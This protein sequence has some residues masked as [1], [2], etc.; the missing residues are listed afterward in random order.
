M[1]GTSNAYPDRS[2]KH[3]PTA[4]VCDVPALQK[5]QHHLLR[6]EEAIPYGVLF[7]IGFNLRRHYPIS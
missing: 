2:R 5:F 4:P 1:S 6:R 3:R 7:C